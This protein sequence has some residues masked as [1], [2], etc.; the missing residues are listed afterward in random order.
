LIISFLAGFEYHWLYLC[1]SYYKADRWL[2]TFIILHIHWPLL[3]YCRFHWYVFTPPFIVSP[4]AF[5]V[6]YGIDAIA[7]LILSFSFSRFRHFADIISALAIFTLH[8]HFRSA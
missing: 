4:L 7:I 3:T 1:F 8:C 5:A 6:H 2:A